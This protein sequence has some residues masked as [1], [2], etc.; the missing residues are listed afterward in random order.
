MQE[1]REELRMW[2]GS[3]GGVVRFDVSRRAA[4]ASERDRRR[5]V[6]LF[7][8][9]SCFPKGKNKSVTGRFRKTPIIPSPTESA[10]LSEEKQIVIFFKQRDFEQLVSFDPSTANVQSY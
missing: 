10:S 1:Q 4:P 3:E 9:F 6:L 2:T 7:S 5:S 8:L